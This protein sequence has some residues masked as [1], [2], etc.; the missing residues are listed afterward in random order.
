MKEL[1][2][3]CIVR[4]HITTAYSYLKGVYKYDRAKI[5]LVVAGNTT[6]NHGQK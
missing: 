4:G 2:A 3:R 1:A 6:E 5:S